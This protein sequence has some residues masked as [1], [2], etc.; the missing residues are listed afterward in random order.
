MVFPVHDSSCAAWN[1][2][3]I[4]G[5]SYATTCQICF[6][7]DKD[8]LQSGRIGKSNVMPLETLLAGANLASLIGK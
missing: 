8:H 6:L 4:A 7:Q 3:E 5:E 2:D 1:D